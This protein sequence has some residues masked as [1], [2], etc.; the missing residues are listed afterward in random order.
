MTIPARNDGSGDV[1]NSWRAYFRNLIAL[2]M[3][4]VA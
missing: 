3:L 1:R 4:L 2:T